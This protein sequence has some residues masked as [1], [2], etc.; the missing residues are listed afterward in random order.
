MTR[1]LKRLKFFNKAQTMKNK[2]FDMLEDNRKS[3]TKNLIDNEFNLAKLEQ[4]VASA[5]SCISR[6]VFQLF[7]DREKTSGQHDFLTDSLAK[8]EVK[9]KNM[10][11]NVTE[12]G[13]MFL[14]ESVNTVTFTQAV[15]Y[16]KPPGYLHLNTQYIFAHKKEPE[17]D[18][19]TLDN[20]EEDS[21]REKLKWVEPY[22]RQ[23]FVS[24]KLIDGE[25]SFKGDRIQDDQPADTRLRR[26][27][28]FNI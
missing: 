14:D 21:L 19:G 13:V 6:I 25:K 8:C 22:M 15:E 27:E 9:L 1:E 23:L 10:L 26:R 12:K 4:L 24:K 17:T 28:G 16:S 2:E 20:H 11:Q 3:Q 5:S 18:V 7:D